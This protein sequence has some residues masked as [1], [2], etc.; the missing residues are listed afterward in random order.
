MKNFENVVHGQ[1]NLNWDISCT[2]GI[3]GVVIGTGRGGGGW[4]GG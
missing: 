1:K 3:C 2:S 4:G